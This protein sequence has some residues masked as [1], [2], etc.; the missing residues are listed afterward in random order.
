MEG[1]G[2]KTH[3]Y[4]F[5]KHRRCRN[6]LGDLVVSGGVPITPQYEVGVNSGAD[7]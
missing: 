5:D 4:R 2:F 1:V 7:P 6:G 3:V